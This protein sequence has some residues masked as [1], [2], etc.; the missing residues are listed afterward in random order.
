M[1]MTGPLLPARLRP[2]IVGVSLVSIVG[3]CDQHRA[4]G[5]TRGAEGQSSTVACAAI[6]AQADSAVIAVRARQAVRRELRESLHVA[7]IEPS[8]RGR[9]RVIVRRLLWSAARGAYEER[10]AFVVYVGPG[11]SAYVSQDPEP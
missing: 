8:S 4:V 5:E 3:A 11:D 10:N 2:F 9:H 1:V 6:A 7:L